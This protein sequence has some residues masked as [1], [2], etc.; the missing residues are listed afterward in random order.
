MCENIIYSRWSGNI[1]LDTIQRLTLTS[2]ADN[3]ARF[4]GRWG[5][6]SSRRSQASS[7]LPFFV[8]SLSSVESKLH[9]RRRFSSFLS[10]SSM[11]DFFGSFEAKAAVSEWFLSS[12]SVTVVSSLSFRSLAF[13]DKEGSRFVESVEEG[14]V[15]VLSRLTRVDG[16]FRQSI[17]E[18]WCCYRSINVL[19]LTTS[20]LL[21]MSLSCNIF[22]DHSWAVFGRSR[23]LDGVWE[24]PI[25]S[26][27]FIGIVCRGKGIDWYADKRWVWTWEYFPRN[28]WIRFGTQGVSNQWVILRLIPHVNHFRQRGVAAV[29]TIT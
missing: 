24:Q 28:C 11:V 23:W 21:F 3:L 5:G 19:K 8:T 1:P 6:D 10:P 27:S 17:G 15:A 16:G 18:I 26:W 20:S 22:K 14:D 9:V 13:A 7:I 29:A 25:S 2:M 4:R 12:C